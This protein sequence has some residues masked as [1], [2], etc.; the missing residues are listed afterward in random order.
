MLNPESIA[1][2]LSGLVGWRPAADGNPTGA[3]HLPDAL[4]PSRSGLYVQDAS[5]LLTLDVLRHLVPK[6][7]T[8]ESWLLRLHTD[9]LLRFVPLLAQGQGLDGRVLLPQTPLTTWPGRVGNTV[10][11]LSRFVGIQLNFRRMLG[12]RFSIPRLSL[13][14]DGVLTQPLPLYFYANDQAEPVKVLTLPVGNVANFPCVFTPP[15]ALALAFAGEY[16]GTGYVGYYEDDLPL[17]V[18]ALYR[19]FNG[20]PCGCAN[21]PYAVWGQYV[22]PLPFSVQPGYLDAGRLLF[23]QRYVNL[24]S[25]N[26]GLSLDFVGYCDVATALQS[27]DNQSRLAPLVQ[28]AVAIR[29]LEAL[30][31]SPNITQLTGRQDV[32]ADAY[33]QLTRFQ[34]QLYG[35]KDSS[36][37]AVY[38]SQLGKLTLDLTGLDAACQA[39]THQRL[40]MGNLVR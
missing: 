10:N 36:T 20:G 19:D 4:L 17:G 6:A 37:D 31:N 11:K 18:H 22:R 28:K 40:S 26:F 13:Q 7:E 25:Q 2:A 23:D 9:A 35:G 34:A 8:L 14:L 27:A 33:A 16:G 39:Q 5:E 12:V 15:A 24:D 21:D 3:L 1:A 29:L 38:P 32:Q 30:T